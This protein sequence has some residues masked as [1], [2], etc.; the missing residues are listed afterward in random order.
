[1]GIENYT[2]NIACAVIETIFVIFWLFLFIKYH[3]RYDDYIEAVDK[4][5]YLMTSLFFIGYGMNEL[6][7]IDVNKAKA[8]KKI[9]EMAQLYNEYA[10]FYYYTKI[11]AQFTYCLTF[12]PIAFFVGA[13]TGDGMMVLVGIIASFILPVYFE[14]DISSQLEKRHEELMQDFPHILSQMSLLLN[15]G[16]PLREVLRKLSVRKET[17]FYQEMGIMVKMIDNG[18][19]EY[20]AMRQF[21]D[22]CGV[23]EIRK[24]S[25]MVMQ[26]ITRGSEGMAASLKEMSD[27]IWNERKNHVRQLGE[28]V[29][30]RLLIPIMMIFGGIL[31]MVIVPSLSSF[32]F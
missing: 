18:D 15:A 16:M 8:K 24:F 26:N 12:L 13:I 19:S 23:P 27:E 9:R 20:D 11:A 14:F 2:V 29:S 31:V 25:L 17:L 32:N 1:M 5:T 22:R 4:K 28:K 3:S 6:M 10:E 30:A 21:A 7:H